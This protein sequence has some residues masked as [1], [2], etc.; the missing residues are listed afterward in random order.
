MHQR[1]LL[2]PAC[3]MQGTDYASTVTKVS[4][5]CDAEIKKCDVHF[6]LGDSPLTC[7]GLDC[8]FDGYG[9]ALCMDVLRIIP[10]C[11]AACCGQAG[12]H[13]E[14]REERMRATTLAAANCRFGPPLPLP[15]LP[16][17]PLVLVPNQPKL[18]TPA[19]VFCGYTKCSCDAA[20]PTVN[21]VSLGYMLERLT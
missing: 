20:C 17:L 14:E 5:H 18:P 3:P 8:T 6:A 7:S 9:E 4:A 19:A 21:G 16:A 13:E 15:A 11:P 2:A 1:P 12:R 10:P